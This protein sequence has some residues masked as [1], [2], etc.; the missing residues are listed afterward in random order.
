[1]QQGVQ[2]SARLQLQL[3]DAMSMLFSPSDSEFA[4][5]EKEVKA[6]PADGVPS[7]SEQNGCARSRRRASDDA[8]ASFPGP[9]ISVPRTAQTRFQSDVILT[10]AAARLPAS[11]SGVVAVKLRRCSIVARFT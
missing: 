5:K 10:K 8:R 2:L 4:T 1:M 9:S 11:S 7:S 3:Q 6:L